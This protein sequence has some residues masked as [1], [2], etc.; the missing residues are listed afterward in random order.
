VGDSGVRLRGAAGRGYR[1]PAILEKF[2]PW[3]GN[4]Q[5]KP[6]VSR[7]YEA[8]VD[9]PLAGRRVKL[10]GGWFYQEYRNL[11]QAAEVGPFTWQMVNTAHAFARGLEG[12]G[13]VA[14][15]RD[16]RLLLAYTWTS[17]WDAGSARQILAVP[18]Q[19]GTVSLVATPVAGL[20]T[21]LDW[22]VES[23]MLDSPPNGESIRRPGYARVDLFTKYGWTPAA[24]GTVKEAAL[25]LAVRNLLD[26][27]YEERRG[28]PAPGATF[29][30]GAQIKM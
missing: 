8:G 7:S 3:M 21:Q 26:R 23:D 12:T 28:Y 2:D 9:V 13:D 5:L 19:R 4:P 25:T 18:R 17:S 24:G 20:E 27:E 10:S 15:A 11:I 14:L 29:M 30:A 16:L 1:T 22:H 6:E